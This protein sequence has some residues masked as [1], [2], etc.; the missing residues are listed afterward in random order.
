MAYNKVIYDGNTL[1]DL[2]DSTIGPEFVE[3]GKVFYDAH[4]TRQ[5][6]I[7]KAYILDDYV[8]TDLTGLN[9]LYEG[10][11]L[12]FDGTNYVDTGVSLFSTDNMDKDF[13][14]VI[15]GITADNT[16]GSGSSGERCLLGAMY[17]VSPYPGFIIR[18]SNSAGAGVIGLTAKT[19]Y[20]IIVITRTNG[21]LIFSA[22]SFVSGVVT[23]PTGNT[24]VGATVVRVGNM[25]NC[26]TTH[27]TTITLGCE[28]DKNGSPY[29]YCGGSI[30]S[31]TIAM[32]D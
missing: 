20:P 29:R 19:Y 5:V 31:I 27:E 2:T 15:R 18:V 13:R 14:I 11:N 17:E 3:E 12:V 28:K 22:A 9:V 7:A 25:N 24:N 6:G 21:N 4:G 26:K 10:S 16:K 8:D 30:E 32:A 23:N 1:I